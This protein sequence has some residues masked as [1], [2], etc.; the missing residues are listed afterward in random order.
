MNVCIDTYFRKV[1]KEFKVLHDKMFDFLCS[2]FGKTLLDPILKYAH[3]KVICERVQ[4]E[5]LQEAHGYFTI[6]VS[7]HDEHK[8]NDR[9]KADLENGK[10][11]WCLNN[12]QMK[13]KEYRI[14]IRDIIKDLEIN[15]I[16]NLI[17]IKDDNGINSFIIACLRGYD[18]LVDFFISVGADVDG[19][20]GFF[21]PLTAACHDGHLKTVEILL[22]GGSNIDNANSQGETPLYTAC[23][24]GH[25]SLVQLLI[26]KDADINKQNKYSRTPLYTSCMLDHATI[27]SL[28]IDK[29][30]NV[31]QYK[32]VIIAA[33]LG[34]ND[35]IV[36]KLITNDCCLN[37]VDIEGKTALFIACEEG[38][39]KIVKLLID[40]NAD[41]YKVDSHGNTPL[42][43]TCCAGNYDIV[44]MLICK[45]SDINMI[46]VDLE[47][48]LHKACRKGSLG[49]IQKL[50]DF[51]AD[52]NKANG[53]V[54]TPAHI[55]K[56]EG[57]IMDEH[58]LKSLEENK[59]EPTE[60]QNLTNS[61]RKIV[62]NNL[63]RFGWTPLYEACING[64]IETVTSL[65]R[66]RANV[67]MKT[68]SGEMPLVAVCQQGH[69]FLL[70]VLLDKGADVDEALCCAVQKG[71]IRT[72]NM[73]LYKGG[74]VSYKGVDGK[75]LLTLACEQ[76]S[77]EIVKILLGKGADLNDVNGQTLIHIVCKTD[78]DDLLKLLLDMGLDLTIHDENGRYPLFVSLDKGFDNLSKHLI[79]QSCSIAI[80]ERDKKTALISAFES[81]NMEL[82]KSL[83]LNG[84]AENLSQF[85]EIML[86]HACRLGLRENVE[87]LHRNGT[88]NKTIYKFKYTL[89]ILA[90][91]GGNDDLSEYLQN[92]I[93]SSLTNTERLRIGRPINNYC[94]SYG[95]YE[96]QIQACMNGEI[97]LERTKRNF[98]DIFIEQ[99][100]SIWFEQTPL[101]LEIRRGQS[102]RVKFLIKHGVNVNLTFED[103]SF[104]APFLLFSM[105]VKYGY[106][107]LFAACQRKCN[108][109]VIMLLENGANVNKAL[110]DACREGY[111]D[112]VQFLLQK[113]ADV[114]SIGRFGQTAL[115]A[116][117]IGGYSTIVK[118]LI[119]QGSV[120]DTK[121]KCE[122]FIHEPTCLHAAYQRNNYKT[123][124]LL[125]KRG[126]SIDTVDNFNRTMLNKACWDG[127]YKIVEILMNKGVDIN[128]SDSYG[129]TPLV[130]SVLQT[131]EDKHEENAYIRE[132]R[133]D[134]SFD[135]HFF[136]QEYVTG[137][138][139]Y[140]KLDFESNINNHFEVIQLLVGNGAD[141]N[142]A[143][144]EGRTPLSLAKE[145]GNMQLTEILLHKVLLQCKM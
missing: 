71:Y 145:I 2:F 124:Q 74:D 85:N 31:Y 14:K 75:S 135:V 47:T 141:I 140:S 103:R 105:A 61:N 66:N 132:M 78:D 83:V 3:D 116:A 119:D 37:S 7:K 73:L 55:A 22:K 109:I 64:D 95:N 69:G 43:A 144:T 127:N 68:D 89:M 35:K 53:D 28:L 51:G 97:K 13:F 142:K 45:G 33:T 24:G 63:I 122:R 134:Y 80:S 104:D 42:H 30:A 48:P 36:E 131:I 52:I 12:S 130:L 27:V 79:K 9:I 99:N 26:E 128:A 76:G 5:S 84:Y 38:Y 120:I 46:D 15:L 123:V 34:G 65:I 19:Q 126:A 21:T 25:Y 121:V 4:L 117:C 94:L 87:I 96:V 23:V 101:C 57:A 118:Y 106:T 102:D 58:I 113:G 29:G 20:I 41:I 133:N 62:T 91:I 139:T 138:N 143:D 10:I 18:E 110:Y 77:V 59:T 92:S 88:D 67:N 49:V 70:Q 56:S 8:Y 60:Q 11:H 90:D 39:I 40:N 82:S 16:R 107:P 50:L 44:S 108:E 137:W 54:H 136:N 129:A 98:F 93:T 1:N 111:L 32:D 6:M 115:Y 100:E 114:N 72:I 86:Y 81:G 17:N 125:I 112:T